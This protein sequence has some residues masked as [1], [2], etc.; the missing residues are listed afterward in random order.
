MKLGYTAF[1]LKQL[2]KL[3][4]QVSSRILDYWTKWQNSKILESVEKCLWVISSAS[5][6]IV[7]EIIGFCA[8]SKTMNL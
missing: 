1:A 4:K 7:L 2:K 5:G 8:K 3:D 6:V